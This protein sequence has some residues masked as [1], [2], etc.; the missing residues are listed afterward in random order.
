MKESARIVSGVVFDLRVIVGLCGIVLS[1]LTHELF[2]IMMHWGEM[3]GIH[4]FPDSQAIVEVI[5][6]PTAG[7]DLAAEEAIAYLITMVTMVLTAMLIGDI[8]DARNES[9]ATS[10][11]LANDFGDCYAAEDEQRTRDHLSSILGI[12]PLT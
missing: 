11:V 10:T 2:H 9:L 7:Y 5:F 4:L 8:N 3:E 6:T 1:V 12:Q